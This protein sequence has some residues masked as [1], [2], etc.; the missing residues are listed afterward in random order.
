V[1]GADCL[2]HVQRWLWRLWDSYPCPV[3]GT[4]WSRSLGLVL[5]VRVEFFD[6]SL[7]HCSG[8]LCLLIISGQRLRP[9][10]LVAGVL[11]GVSAVGGEANRVVL[12]FVDTDAG[13]WCWYSVWYVVLCTTAQVLGMRDICTTGSFFCCAEGF[14]CANLNALPELTSSHQL[15]PRAQ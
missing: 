1:H 10:D 13:H 2:T 6:L 8:D 5:A 3:N 15:S 4:L 11:R 9:L 7:C 14:S 12:L